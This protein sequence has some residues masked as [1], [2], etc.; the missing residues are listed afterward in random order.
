[1]WAM[2]NRKSDGG[3]PLDAPGAP[4]QAVSVSEALRAYTLLGAYSGREEGVKGSLE[5]GKLA[6]LAVLDR[7]ILAIPPEEI[8]EVKVDMT[9]IGGALVFERA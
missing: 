6:D 7:D 2:V 8:R 1:M 5:V 3:G 4:S 9:F